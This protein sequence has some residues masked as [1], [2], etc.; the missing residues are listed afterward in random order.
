MSPPAGIP[1]LQSFV[2]VF[3]LINVSSEHQSVYTIIKNMCGKIRVSTS[4]RLQK[5][6]F[7][8]VEYSKVVYIYHDAVL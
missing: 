7:I 3:V 6:Y 4:L 2:D 5:I 8:G 1:N